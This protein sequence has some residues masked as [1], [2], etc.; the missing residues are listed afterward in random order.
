[1]GGQGAAQ[2]DGRAGA[3]YG[4]AGDGS[5]M[6]CADF[7]AH[8]VASLAG[9]QRSSKRSQCLRQDNVRPAVQDARNL[10]VSLHG[11]GGNTAFGAQFREADAEFHYKGTNAVC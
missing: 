5:V 11:H 2:V 1:M 3:R 8:G 9:V 6:G 10:G 7:N 4:A